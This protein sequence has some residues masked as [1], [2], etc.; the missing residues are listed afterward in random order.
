MF[1]PVNN[2]TV[3]YKMNFLGNQCQWLHC[4]VCRVRH[5]TVP[6]LRFAKATRKR[7]VT[8]FNGFGALSRMSIGDAVGDADQG[9]TGGNADN[10]V[11]E[12]GTTKLETARVFRVVRD[13]YDFDEVAMR[14]DLL[15]RRRDLTAAERDEETRLLREVL[16][17]PKDGQFGLVEVWDVRNDWDDSDNTN[18]KDANDKC[19]VNCY[20]CRTEFDVDRTE[21]AAVLAHAKKHGGIVYVAT[22]E[23]RIDPR[24]QVR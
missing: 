17:T 15:E 22:N 8:T 5:P 6:P 3:V 11:S 21:V 23:I 18:D 20:R 7:Q 24:K 9:V 1:K 12:V 19:L 10:H 16:W 4:D 14:L 2:Q 13:P